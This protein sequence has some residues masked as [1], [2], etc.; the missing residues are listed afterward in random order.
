MF[1][2]IGGIVLGAVV[3]TVIWFFVWRNNKK[4][5]LEAL[6]KLEGL[7]D[8]DKTALIKELLAKWGIK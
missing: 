3:S 5:F 6:V 1:G 8:A 7:A 2:F 4:K